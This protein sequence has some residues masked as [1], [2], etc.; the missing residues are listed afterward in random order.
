M[1]PRSCYGWGGGA[2]RPVRGREHK[3]TGSRSVTDYYLNIQ[4]EMC[5][6]YNL[7]SLYYWRRCNPPDHLQAQGIIPPPLPPVNHRIYIQQGEVERVLTAHACSGSIPPHTPAPPFLPT[8]VTLGR[9]PRKVLCAKQTYFYY[10]EVYVGFYG[11]INH[12]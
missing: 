8:P 6:H 3:K 9:R 1:D 12:T 10:L 7:Y 5:I 11:P 4:M 2:Q